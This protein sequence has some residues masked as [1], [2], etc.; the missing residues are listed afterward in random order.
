MAASATWIAG[1]GTSLLVALYFGK[2]LS[3]APL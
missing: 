1:V 2:K 3:L